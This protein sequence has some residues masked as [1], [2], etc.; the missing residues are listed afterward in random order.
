MRPDW[1]TPRRRRSTALA[2][3]IFV[4]VLWSVGVASGLLYLAGISR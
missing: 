2:F 4:V 1:M 3:V